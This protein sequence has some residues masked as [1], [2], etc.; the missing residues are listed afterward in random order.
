VSQRD[1]GVGG[2]VPGGVISASNAKLAE[3]VDFRQVV[4]RGSRRGKFKELIPFG[5]LSGCREWVLSLSVAFH[6]SLLKVFRK[7]PFYQVEV[8]KS[9]WQ[10]SQSSVGHANRHQKVIN[11]KVVANRSLPN[12]LLPIGHYQIGCCQR[13]S[14]W[15]DSNLFLPATHCRPLKFYH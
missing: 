10:C 13:V 5:R 3:M 2:T 9:R 15:V 6:G 4:G 8:R 7:V 1:T 14:H 11:Q 12:R